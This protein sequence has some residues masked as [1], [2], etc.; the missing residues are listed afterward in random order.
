MMGKWT[1]R[2]AI[3][4]ESGHNETKVINTVIPY[5]LTLAA[6]VVLSW[7]TPVYTLE[8]Q[9]EMLKVIAFASGLLALFCTQ[10]Q[11]T[12]DVKQGN[13]SE[14]VPACINDTCSRCIGGHVFNLSM[15]QST[16][17]ASNSA[18]S[19]FNISSVRFQVTCMG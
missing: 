19:K 7:T 1:S 13:H 2:P 6:I 12:S 5:R 3:S 14:D 18:S 4:A 10:G 11:T 15:V 17:V 9:A 8:F 16:L